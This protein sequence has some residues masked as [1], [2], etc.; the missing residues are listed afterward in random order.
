VTA[1]TR[2]WT[3]FWFAPKDALTLGVCRL[4]FFGLLFVNYADEHWAPWAEVSRT[5]WQ[6]IFLFEKFH[7]PV[8]SGQQLFICEI[9]W[10]AAIA[11]ACVG[12]L[13]RIST[14]TAFVLGLYLLGLR[15]NWGKASHDDA[16]PVLILLIL[17]LSRCGD[18]LSMDA[19]FRRPKSAGERLPL[20]SGEYRWPIRAVWLVISMVFFNSAIAK[21]R[22]SGLDWALSEN[23]AVLMVR[24]NYFNKPVTDWGLRLANIPWFGHGM[25][26]GAILV[27]LCFPLVLFSR[28]ARRIL[29]PAA[30]LMQ[31]GNKFLLG[32]DFTV[33]MFAYVFFIDWGW[34]LGRRRLVGKTATTSAVIEENSPREVPVH[35]QSAEDSIFE[36]RRQV[37][38][39]P[40]PPAG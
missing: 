13:T 5:F 40:P 23:L 36:R 9:V 3:D 16:A 4:L 37:Q 26:L 15:H 6:P 39:V 29:V 21:L 10:K 25:G 32:V 24:L 14:A 8:L 12:L 27:E 31:L 33:F 19:L 34:L 22:K 30:F 38:R 11:F 7:I 17:A 2:R 1:L 18:A 28:I 20:E 35:T